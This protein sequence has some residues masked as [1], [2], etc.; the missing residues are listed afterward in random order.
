MKIKVGDLTR[1]QIL[2]ICDK[3][4]VGSIHCQIQELQGRL[5]K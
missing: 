3:S 5:Q 2:K 1:R 4:T